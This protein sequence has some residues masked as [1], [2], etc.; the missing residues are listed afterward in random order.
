MAGPNRGAGADPGQPSEHWPIP[1]W[2]QAYAKGWFPMADSTSGRLALWRSRS[3]ALIPL[4]QTFC[5]PRSVRRHLDQHSFQLSLNRSFEAV[6]SGC[7][8][9][10]DTWISGELGRI[11]GQLHRAGWAHS[12]E[13]WQGQELAAGLL[14]IGIGGC[15]IGESMMHR[16]AHAGNAMLV[17]LVEALGASG[18]S[19]FDV[20]LSNPH[21]ERFGCHEID[22]TAYMALLRAARSHPTTLRLGESVVACEGWMR[23]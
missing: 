2:I 8:D 13:V 6:L 3:R 9:R 10:P 15:W 5:V 17:G 21:L 4:D 19:L 12:V 1:W 23:E 11:Y 22:D 7:A 14:A 18:F 16:R 20:Q